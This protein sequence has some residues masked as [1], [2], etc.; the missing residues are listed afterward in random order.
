M[1]GLFRQEVLDARRAQWLGGV[2]LIQPVKLWWLAAF[3]MVSAVSVIIFLMLG[4]YTRRTRVIG[5]LVPSAGLVTL[6]APASGVLAQV[7]I[8]EGDNVQRGQTLARILVPNAS[9]KVNNT[10][11]AVGEQIA[12]RGVAVAQ[13]YDAQLNQLQARLDGLNAQGSALRGELAALAQETS[14]RAEQLDL[15]QQTLTRYRQLQ[16]QQFVTALQVQEQQNLWLEQRATVQTLQ[17]NAANI[18]RQLAAL[19]QELAEIPAQQR[20]LQSALLRDRAELGQESLEAAAR[21]DAVVSAPIDGSISALM[22]LP[23]QAVQSGQPIMTL[24]PKASTLEA[25]LLVPSRAVGFIAPGDHVL[26]R[27]QAFP[28][29]K[30]GQGRGEVLRVSRSAIGNSEMAAQIDDGQASEPLYRVVV[31]LDKQT[32][33]A[34]GADEPLKPGMLLEADVLGERRKLWEWVLEPLYSVT[35]RSS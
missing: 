18:R 23:G 2:S 22:G 12:Q 26:L 25:H 27:Y 21:G 8:T 13:S 7:P 1:S 29:Q 30:F 31:K 28:Y 32:V 10:A 15:S 34:F 35:G 17:R 4:D 3:A 5:Q 19:E 20:A 24:L 6:P 9:S 14:T 33:S 16:Q 11:S